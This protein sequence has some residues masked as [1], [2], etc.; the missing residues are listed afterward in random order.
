M[1]AATLRS[2]PDPSRPRSSKVAA[3]SGAWSRGLF[4]R[5]TENAPVPRRAVRSWSGDCYQGNG[6][7][8][9]HPVVPSEGTQQSD[10]LLHRPVREG[11][12][13][14]D[15]GQSQASQEHQVGLSSTTTASIFDSALLI[16]WLR[17]CRFVVSGL[18]KGETYVFRVQAINELGLSEESQESAPITVKAALSPFHSILYLSSS[19]PTM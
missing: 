13:G 1:E 14:L 19:E 6:H 17:V 9:P 4:R 3:V 16:V 12:Q 5:L 7:V 18:T 11:V 15:V 2:R 8:R 10:W